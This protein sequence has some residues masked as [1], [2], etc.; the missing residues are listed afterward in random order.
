MTYFYGDIKLK[1]DGNISVPNSLKGKIWI[2]I[3]YIA[4]WKKNTFYV[5]TSI[6][7]FLE[8]NNPTSDKISKSEAQPKN[9]IQ[10]K[11]KNRNFT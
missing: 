10:T 4:T 7:D 6:E 8:F 11:F 2:F 3:H 1:I 5:C 9:K